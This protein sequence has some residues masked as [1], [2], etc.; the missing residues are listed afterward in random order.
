MIVLGEIIYSAEIEA[1]RLFT[2]EGKADEA[3]PLLE[4]VLRDEPQNAPARFGLGQSLHDCGE[5]DGALAHLNEAL[6]LQPDNV[7]MLWQLAWILA[8]WPEAAIRIA[9]QAGMK[10]KIAAK[11]DRADRQ[12]FVDKTR[13]SLS[14]LSIRRPA[15][16]AGASKARNLEGELHPLSAIFNKFKLRRMLLKL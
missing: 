14:L 1:G 10:L 16:N 15:T 8:T 7:R 9:A 2:A 4:Q 12:Y 6:R 11:V 3:I 13:Q 5:S